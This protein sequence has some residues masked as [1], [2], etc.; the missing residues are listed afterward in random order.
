MLLKHRTASPIRQNRQSIIK[1]QT[2]KSPIRTPTKNETLQ[3]TKTDSPIIL[4]TPTS[5][6]SLLKTKETMGIL[7]SL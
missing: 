1:Q 4:K 7:Y 3:S 6:K 5:T 2:S